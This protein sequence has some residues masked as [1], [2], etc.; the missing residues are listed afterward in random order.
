MKVR[1]FFY[2]KPKKQKNPKQILIDQESNKVFGNL[3]FDLYFKT[4]QLLVKL[5]NWNVF[6][7][8][9]NEVNADC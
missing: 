4:F 2:H 9:I 6:Y 5:T 8:F 7:D 1:S 3:I